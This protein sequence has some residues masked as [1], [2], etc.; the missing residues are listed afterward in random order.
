[1][2]LV[3]FA[4]EAV[5][6]VLRVSAVAAEGVRHSVALVVLHAMGCQCMR[7]SLRPACL[8]LCVCVCVLVCSCVCLPFKQPI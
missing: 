5:A 1:M 2:L 7:G 4:P 3:A 8:S 6:R